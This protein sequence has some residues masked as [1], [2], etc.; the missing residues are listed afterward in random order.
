[1]TML[2]PEANAKDKDVSQLLSIAEKER[3]ANNYPRA[4]DLYQKALVSAQAAKN[5]TLEYE[6]RAYLAL[7]HN[8][9]GNLRKALELDNENVALIGRLPEEERMGRETET[10]QAIAADYMVLKDFA[11]AIEVQKV[12]LTKS[13]S[14]SPD[15]GSLGRAKVRQKLGIM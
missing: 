1:L 9:A 5:P 3:K 12:V 11:K 10:L 14:D 6:A 8:L 2:Q 13:M 4:I 15:Q 7:T